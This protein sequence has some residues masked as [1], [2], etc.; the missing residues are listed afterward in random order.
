[1]SEPLLLIPGLNCTA[2]V[3]APQVEAFSGERSVVVADVTEDETIAGMARRALAAAP[4]RFALAGLSLGG[5]VAFE[6]LRQAPQ[7]VSRLALLN[8]TARPDGEEATRRRL[9]LIRA[10]E[11]GR[12]AD[13]V[14]PHVEQVLSPAARG[15]AALVTLVT[16]MA[17]E[18]DAQAFVRQHRAAIGR[19]DSRPGLAGISV[20]AL[21]VT[22]RRDAVIP[23]TD[24]HEIADEIPVSQLLVLEECGHLCTLEQ[25]RLVCDALARWLGAGVRPAG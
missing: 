5:Y 14:R 23:P 12:F 1:M 21:V 13:L 9:R 7:R 20:P 16:R 15:N 8:T 10:A 25:P 6:I 24:S 18:T 3:F 2:A 11:S 17:E 4:E 19:M 22:G